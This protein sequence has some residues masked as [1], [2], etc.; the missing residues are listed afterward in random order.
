M[1]FK[2]DVSSIDFGSL[3]PEGRIAKCHEMAAEA[4]RLAANA[5]AETRTGYSELAAQWS[6]LA[7]EM[8]S[9]ESQK[10]LAGEE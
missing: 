4:T 10:P 6:A 5:S 9:A 7:S 2:P 3:S 1:S 8:E